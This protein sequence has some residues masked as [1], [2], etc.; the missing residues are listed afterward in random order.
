[1]S[2]SIRKI[3][4]VLLLVSGAILIFGFIPDKTDKIK[5]TYHG[6]DIVQGISSGNIIDP[7]FVVDDS[8][9][10]LLRST[11][12]VI[13]GSFPRS[14]MAGRNSQVML[15]AT[16]TSLI[17]SNPPEIP[18]GTG[19]H[20]LVHLDFPRQFVEPYGQE[21]KP[22]SLT[23]PS[24]FH[25]NLRSGQSGNLQGK[26]WIYLQLK[27]PDGLTVEYPLVGRDMKLPVKDIFGLDLRATRIVAS[28]V[29][30]A[31]FVLLVI[32]K[33]VQKVGARKKQL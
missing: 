22:I 33:L 2:S 26:L 30:I 11:D 23:S 5:F 21:S 32:E 20:I 13:I 18:Q 3:A 17:A 6:S 14:I 24:T 7:S 4:L 10:Q 9:A 12:L 29:G 8:L 19:F 27:N 28:I 1:M 15:T 16:L 25:W 31:G